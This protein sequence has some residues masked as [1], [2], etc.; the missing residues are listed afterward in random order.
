MNDSGDYA[1]PRLI[2]LAAAA[3]VVFLAVGLG[4]ALFVVEIVRDR[5]EGVAK[6]HAEF[7]TRAVLVPA[8]SPLGYTAPV[9]GAR[10]DEIRQMLLREVL[11]DGRDVRIKLWSPDGTII[12]SD[13]QALVGTRF[14]PD[15]ELRTAFDGRIES[16]VSDLTEPG[17]ASERSLGTKLFETY[18]PVR[19]E[20]GGPVVAVFELYQS[21]SAIQSD[22]A[23]LFRTISVSLAMGLFILFLTLLALARRPL[24]RQNQRLREQ[25]GRLRDA[26]NRYRALVEQTPAITYV[27]APDEGVETEYRTVYMSPQ[28]ADVLGYFPDEF[29]SDPDLWLGILHPDDRARALAADA[30]HYATGRSLDEEYRVISRDGR[31]VW[32]HDRAV[33]SNDEAGRLRFSQGLLLDISERK[34]AEEALRESEERYRALVELSPDAICVHADGVIVFANP[35]AVRLFR[36]DGPE[37]LMGVR[38]MDLVHPDF[39]R[40]AQERVR[41]VEQGQTVPLLEERLLRLDG[42][43]FDVEVVG[44]PLEIDGG[45]AVQVVVRDISERKRAEEELRDA[46]RRLQQIDKERQNLLA[47]LVRAQ[48]EERARIAS[49]IHDDSL[50]KITAAT[51]RLDMLKVDRPELAGDERFSKAEEAIRQTIDSMRHLMFELRPYVLDRDGLRAALRLNVEEESKREGS[52]SYHL[53]SRL[54]TEPPQETRII[55]YRIVQE[56]LTNIR[57]HARA[58]RVDITLQESEGGF[59]VEVRD[60]GVGFESQANDRS[61]QGHIGL[62]SMRERAELAGGR[63]R[64]ASVPG[65]GTTVEVWVPDLKENVEEIEWKVSTASAF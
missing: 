10:Y 19:A 43:A 50:Q 9:T 59:S 55:L 65:H 33:I 20:P 23:S 2:R 3:L 48:E 15:E 52:P 58:T 32:L 51:M 11:S 36:A 8:L 47:H 5:A 34:R 63:F 60:D 64:I 26:E 1:S 49:D 16:S 29:V 6:F 22:V 28:I 13:D 30:D 61:P 39:V 38:V 44:M 4:L 42:S 14:P 37:Q 56:A 45:R 62:T 40:I 24:R 7:V 54:Q 41:A 57:K 35:A 25:A 27:D 21:Y 31:V 18:V 46:H 17:S 53:D 12:F